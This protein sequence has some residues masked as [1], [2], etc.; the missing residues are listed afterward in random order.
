MKEPALSSE[1]Q[2]LVGFP[3]NRVLRFAT[4]VN[5]TTFEMEASMPCLCCFRGS[6]TR[7]R[8][9]IDFGAEVDAELA[10]NAQD[11]GDM[12]FMTLRRCVDAYV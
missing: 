10:R 12:G 6:Q 5:N 2:C 8:S 9:R 7:C 1:R 3:G 11:F 4:L